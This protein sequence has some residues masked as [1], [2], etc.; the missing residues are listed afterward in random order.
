LTHTAKTARNMRIDAATMIAG[1]KRRLVRAVGT[2]IR[3]QRTH[4]GGNDA[5]PCTGGEART[6]AHAEW[7]RYDARAGACTVERGL[8]R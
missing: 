1:T 6:P 7:C 4:T 5:R 3:L 8:R 2:C